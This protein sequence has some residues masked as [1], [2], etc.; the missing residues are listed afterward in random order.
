MCDALVLLIFFPLAVR[1]DLI[2]VHLGVHGHAAVRVEV[3]P[4][5]ADLLSAPGLHEARSV[6]PIPFAVKLFPAGDGLAVQI[7]EPAPR[8]VLPPSASGGGVYDDLHETP[9]DGG[10]LGAGG[11]VLGAE[12]VATLAVHHACLL[13]GLYRVFHAVGNLPLVRENLRFT[14]HGKGVPQFVGVTLHNGRHLFAGDGG[15]GVKGLVPGA[16]DNPLR[17]LPL[18]IGRIVGGGGNVIK[19]TGREG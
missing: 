9:Q 12:T 18:H 8:V 5:I 7:I 16:G 19:P 3:V 4:A 14:G 11:G 17:G 15:V 13:H 1:A 10:G 2:A 6:K